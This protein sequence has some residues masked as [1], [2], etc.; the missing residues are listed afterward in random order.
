MYECVNGGLSCRISPLRALQLSS[1]V[2]RVAVPNKKLQ[3]PW[4][5]AVSTLVAPASSSPPSWDGHAASESW[6]K[7]PESSP[8]KSSCHFSTTIFP[9]SQWGNHNDG[10]DGLLAPCEFGTMKL[11]FKSVHW[12][13]YC[14]LA[15]VASP[16]SLPSLHV[17][18]QHNSVAVHHPLLQCP[19][20]LHPFCES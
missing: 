17:L 3:N 4:Q 13:S 10:L 5:G 19:A 7:S 1:T 8:H 11:F 20:R 16:Q 6:V 12:T 2:T 18:L 9:S 15:P 14:L